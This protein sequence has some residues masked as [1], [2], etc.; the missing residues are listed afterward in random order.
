M[1]LLYECATRWE[2]FTEQR[3]PIALVR[4]EGGAKRRQRPMILT[5]EQFELVVATLREPYR[6]MVQIAQCLGLR[7]SEIA[8]LQWDD[9]DFEK[10]QLLVQRSFVS[11][12]I[13]DV[14]TE[15]SQDY[16]P[17]HPSLTKIVLAWSKQAVPTAKGWVSANRMT[18]RPYHPTEIQKRHLRPSGCCVVACPTCGA[19]P[20]VWCWQ[21]EPTANSKRAL[22]HDT[23]KIEAGKLGEIRLA[24]VPPHVPFVA[25][26]D[27]GS[28]EGA[29]GIDASCLYPNDDEYLRTGDVVIEAG[30]EWK[31]R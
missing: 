27:R 18:N 1:H 4:V 8:A 22:I 31:R 7:V 25:G 15:Y 28:D 9:F 30:S 6:T 5:V 11:G 23:R 13:D 26:R 21:G 14:K 10:N 16:V 12:R 24:H 2:L 29:A 3:N 20:G 19:A 17:L